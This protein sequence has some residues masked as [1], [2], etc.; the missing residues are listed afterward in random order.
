MVS[1]A[2]ELF[3]ELEADREASPSLPGEEPAWHSRRY[4]RAS[5]AMGAG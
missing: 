4:P 3:A 5:R 1:F 2:T